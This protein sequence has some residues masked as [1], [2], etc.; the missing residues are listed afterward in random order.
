M[1]QFVEDLELERTELMNKLNKIDSVLNGIRELCTH[2]DE[3]GYDAYVKIGN[4]HKDI[5]KC[6]ICGHEITL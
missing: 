2:R 4:T 1:I 3:N 6:N 5:Y